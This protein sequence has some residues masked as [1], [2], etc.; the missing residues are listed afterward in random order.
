MSYS[1]LLDLHPVQLFPLLQFGSQ[2]RST[3][4]LL[5]PRLL[6]AETRSTG[7]FSLEHRTRLLFH[8]SMHEQEEPLVLFVQESLLVARD[9]EFPLVLLQSLGVP[10]ARLF[11]VS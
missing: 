4:S 9:G 5:L 10:L 3:L 8:R 1:V 6:F 2:L 11:F 7:R